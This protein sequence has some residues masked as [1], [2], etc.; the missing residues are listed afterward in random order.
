[1]TIQSRNTLTDT[2]MISDDRVV[3]QNLTDSACELAI[4]VINQVIV[5]TCAVDFSTLH[6]IRRR[7]RFKISPSVSLAVDTSC[8]GQVVRSSRV[9][10]TVAPE[11]GHARTEWLRGG[12]G[13]EEV[14]ESDVVQEC[15][16]I[17]GLVR[18]DLVE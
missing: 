1:M 12:V 16:R 17:E 11:D 18:A 15:F 6:N 14:L 9:C 5:G 2:L 7:W 3:G 8:V 13:V 4:L 10:S